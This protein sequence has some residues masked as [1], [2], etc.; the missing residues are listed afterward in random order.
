MHHVP[1][2][3]VTYPSCDAWIATDTWALIDKQNAALKRVATPNKL[4]PLRKAIRKKVRWDQATRLALMGTEIQ[5]HLDTDNPKE[6]WQLV[7]VWYRH[8]EHTPPPTPMDLTNIGR[9]YC[10]LYTQQDPPGEPICGLVSFD[11]LDNIPDGKEIGSTVKTLCNG[12]T[13]GTSGM[14][15]EDLK[16]WFAEQED[17]LAP[18]LLVVEMV[19]HAFLTG[20]VPT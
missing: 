9:D 7:K 19:Q 16:R 3:P 10:N 6:A 5:T 12:R 13:P 14:K 4:R 1:I 20:M 8:Q 2:P 18:W 15:V 17:T 11:I